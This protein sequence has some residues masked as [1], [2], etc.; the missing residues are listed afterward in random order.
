VEE[1]EVMKTTKKTKKTKGGAKL[2]AVSFVAAG[3]VVRCPACGEPVH[4]EI[5][6]YR[7]SECGLANVKL[8]GVPVYT[9]KKCG[10]HGA[11]IPNV[12]GLHRVLARGLAARRS[13]LK[14]EEIRFLRK[15][16]GFSSVDFAGVMGKAPESISR[17]ESATS[18]MAMD[19]AAERLLRL[20][21]MTRKPMPEY[22]LENLATI[23][24]AEPAPR[25]MVAKQ[26]RRSSWG[27]E[28]TA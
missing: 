22:P 26:N 28:A 9:C 16:L 24:T 18:P 14:P 3:P 1:T 10:E 15:Y 21:V 13:G 8:A 2:D 20:M 7:Y 11:A 5:G 4:A 23:E 27:L 19:P 12:A 17:W 6:E 25:L